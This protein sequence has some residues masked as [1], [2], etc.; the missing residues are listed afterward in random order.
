MPSATHKNY[1]K[2]RTQAAVIYIT[3]YSNTRLWELEDKV[4]PENLQQCL[5]IVFGRTNAV[6]EAIDD[7][8]EKDN[9]FRRKINMRYLETPNRFPTPDTMHNHEPVDWIAWMQQETQD[10]IEGIN[11][12][13]KLLNEE[14]DPFSGNTRN[15]QA[16]T[17]ICRNTSEIPLV[18]KL[19]M[20]L[21]PVKVN[22]PLP[23]RTKPQNKQGTSEIPLD[24]IQH[25]I[26]GKPPVPGNKP[27]KRQINYDNMGHM[28]SQYNPMG[29]DN[30]SYMQLPVDKGHTQMEQFSLNGTPEPKICYRCGYEGHIKRQCNNYVYCDYC[31]T[32]SHHTSVCR[33]YQRQLQSQPVTSSRRSSPAM[34]TEKAKYSRTEDKQYTTEYTRRGRRLVGNYKKALSTNNKQHD[35]NKLQHSQ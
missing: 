26:Q 13:I 25:F 8:L 11:E 18:E 15:T 30:T 34:Q 19:V 21:I 22:N 20:P 1:I 2:D 5:Q 4:P 7:A 31:R 12:E 24:N 3:E 14:D 6:R 33:S 9:S 23:Q 29:E 28:H 27:A 16:S 35:P 10:L 32:Y 17:Q